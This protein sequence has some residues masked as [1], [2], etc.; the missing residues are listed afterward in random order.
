MTFTINEID[1]TFYH[2]TM[3]GMPVIS[4]SYTCNGESFAEWSAEAGMP[5]STDEAKIMLTQFGWE[6]INS[7]DD[8]RE[9]NDR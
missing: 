4:V 6:I 7:S 8:F 5:K 9:G 1:Y 3:N 2:A